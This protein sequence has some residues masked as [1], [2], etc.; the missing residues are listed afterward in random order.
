MKHVILFMDFNRNLVHELWHQP[1]QG[2]PLLVRCG[3]P[4]VSAIIEEVGRGGVRCTI[5]ECTIDN[6]LAL[7]IEATVDLTKAMGRFATIELEVV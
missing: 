3:D 1:P 5:R 4:D 7:S 6:P 2:M